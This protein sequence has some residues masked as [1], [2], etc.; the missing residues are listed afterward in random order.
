LSHHPCNESESLKVLHTKAI[1]INSNPILCIFMKGLAT[2]Y[3]S[4]NLKN[5]IKKN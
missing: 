5:F 1:R 4:N 3:N 2:L